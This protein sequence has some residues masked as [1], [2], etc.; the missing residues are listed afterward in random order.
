MITSPARAQADMADN[1]NKVFLF[2]E[3]ES[4]CTQLALFWAAWAYV[5]EM[6]DSYEGALHVIATGF[7]RRVLLIVL[8]E[9]TTTTDQCTTLCHSLFDIL[10]N[11]LLQQYYSSVSSLEKYPLKFISK[12]FIL[13]AKSTAL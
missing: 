7:A 11:P 5:L 4:I 9:I 2:L 1:T 10:Y 12:L 3:S 13:R 6:D 8:Q